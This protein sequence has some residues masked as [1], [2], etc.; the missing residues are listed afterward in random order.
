MVNARLSEVLTR[1]SIPL[2]LLAAALVFGAACSDDGA[3]DE[4]EVVRG[5]VEVNTD[6]ADGSDEDSDGSADE[7][8]E[9]SDGQNEVF[10]NLEGTIVA[11]AK[12]KVG[13]C[14]NEY[15]YRDRADV[16]QQLTTTVDCTRPHDKELYHASDHPAAEGAPFLRDEISEFANDECLDAF[17]DFVGEEYVLSQLEIGFL[18]PTYEAWISEDFDRQV[19]CYVFPYEE[20]R[21][22]QGSMSGIGF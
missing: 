8:D 18:Q 17:E 15:R 11:P 1:R 20:D 5:I 3:G 10:A 19:T 2:L 14:F 16:L 12:L 9:D 6:D 21:R 22:L 7:S 4:R 13:D